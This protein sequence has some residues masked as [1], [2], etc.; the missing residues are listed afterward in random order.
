MILGKYS[1]YLK[2]GIKNEIS[3]RAIIG[4]LLISPTLLWVRGIFPYFVRT[5][6]W[7]GI[8]IYIIFNLYDLRAKN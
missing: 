3:F 2:N 7:F 5:C 6:V 8:I 4:L 1:N